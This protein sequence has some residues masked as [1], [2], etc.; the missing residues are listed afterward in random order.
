MEKPMILINVF[1]VTYFFG[2]QARKG[3]LV[4]NVFYIIRHEGFCI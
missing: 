3:G 1:N 2:I 4:L